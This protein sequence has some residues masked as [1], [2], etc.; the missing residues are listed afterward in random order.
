MKSLKHIALGA[1]LVAGTFGVTLYSSCS[2]DKCKDVVCNN[3][4]SCNEGVCSCPTGYEGANCE[5]LSR[6]K[7]VGTY[8]GTEICSQG[9]DNYSI[10]L[11][12][13]S[14]ALKLTYTNL[15]NEN[16]TAICTIAATDS[17]T[18]AGSQG[19]ATFSG[20]GRLSTN[21]LTV[22]YTI[23]NSGT[24]NSCVFTGNK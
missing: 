4:G 14:D 17:F 10:T 5:T 23:T 18:F 20:S 21:T 13:N 9:T 6:A 22:H 3:G 2:K 8:A 1:F 24:T 15:Y 7:F 19:T 12:A 16:F 11:A